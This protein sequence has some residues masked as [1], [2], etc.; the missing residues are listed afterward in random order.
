MVNDTKYSAYKQ[1]CLARGLTYDDKQWIDG[2]RESALLKLPRAIRTLFI[3]ILIYGSS[4]NP[5]NLWDT[6]KEDLA[7]DFINQARE[8]GTSVEEAIQKA[9]RIIAHKLNT[10]VTEGRNF[11]H[12]VDR[13]QMDDIDC[14]NEINDDIVNIDGDEMRS[15]LRGKQIEVVDSIKNVFENNM[16]Q[17]CFFY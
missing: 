6:F 10:E 13:F 14:N 3:Q 1:A 16:P 15:T 5:K 9:Y 4:E 11:R 2:L 17:K 12:W 7:G 8:I